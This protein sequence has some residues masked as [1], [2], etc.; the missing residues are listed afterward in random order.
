MSVIKMSA[1]RTIPRLI[2]L[3]LIAAFMAWAALY[4]AN[5]LLSGH[6][7]YRGINTA[8]I[9]S[10]IG[11]PFFTILALAESYFSIKYKLAALEFSSS[12]ISIHQ[13]MSAPRIVNIEYAEIESITLSRGV[14]GFNKR[15]G[16]EI[17]YYTR[18]LGSSEHRVGVDILKALSSLGK[19]RLVSFR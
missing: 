14:V 18:L 17:K 3:Y 4:G 5:E 13:F 8:S 7:S 6:A 12:G 1:A 10:I 16:R 9:L 15:N 11:F 2:A 19:E